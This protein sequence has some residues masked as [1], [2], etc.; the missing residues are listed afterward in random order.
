MEEARPLKRQLSD[1][2]QDKRFKTNENDTVMVPGPKN[3]INS[4][5]EKNQE[6]VNTN[7]AGLNFVEL[8]KL[9]K[10]TEPGKSA[11]KTIETNHS[12]T[13]T[14]EISKAQNLN[15]DSAF[16]P[17]NKRSEELIKLFE[18]KI[19]EKEELLAR[20]S[21]I[22]AKIHEK[23]KVC[24]KI[25]LKSA[26]KKEALKC[27]IKRIRR[28]RENMDKELQRDN[29]NLRKII[30]F[31]KTLSGV[32]VEELGLGRFKIIVRNI[33]DE[34]VF[35]L[36][37]DG[38]T[39]NY[40]LLSATISDS[41]IPSYLRAEINID[42]QDASVLLDKVMSIL[43]YYVLNNLFLYAYQENTGIHSLKG[44]S[45]IFFYLKNYYEN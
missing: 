38:N 25:N 42:K 22:K 20:I 28:E 40:E 10:D 16:F 9:I 27:E 21:E 13:F 11:L 6:E 23:N 24:E 1:E 37:E 12:E 17:I 15:V 31:Y 19:K 32:T 26:E 33:Q 30:E 3:A 4:N 14:N 29:D 39:F 18:L 36:G 35:V 34:F 7:P 41:K 8:S 44:F 5:D 45:S 43:H 2:E